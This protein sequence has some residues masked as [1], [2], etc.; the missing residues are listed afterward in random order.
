[1]GDA[2]YKKISSLRKLPFYPMM[3]SK[4]KFLLV[5]NMLLSLG[6]AAEVASKYVPEIKKELAGWKEGR[7]CAMQI[8]PKGPSLT[9]MKQGDR[10]KVVG[11]GVHDSDVTFMFKNLDAAMPVFVGLQGTHE[12]MAQN[13]IMIQGDNA[14]AQEFNR[15]I[16]LVLAYLF[17]VFA[18]QHLFKAKPKL[19]VKGI[20]N[21]SKVYLFLVPQI[22]VNTIK[23]FK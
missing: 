15:V 10:V 21:K 12:A 13:K 4:A 22:I 9:L 16:A 3:Q 23:H 2:V 5:D 19:G 17:P 1:M 6:S 14:Y 20:I 11:K 18:Y 8:L 7:R